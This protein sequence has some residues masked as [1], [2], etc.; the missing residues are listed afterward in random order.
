MKTKHRLEGEI[1][2]IKQCVNKMAGSP[3]F[4]ESSFLPIPTVLAAVSTYWMHPW[5]QMPLLLFSLWGTYVTQLWSQSTASHS[6][7]SEDLLHTWH[8]SRDGQTGNL[9]SPWSQRVDPV[10]TQPRTPVIF[11][12]RE[13]GL[14]LTHSLSALS[15][16]FTGPK[17]FL[18][19]MNSVSDMNPR[20]L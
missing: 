4:R 20:W 9:C 3:S 10:G 1:R 7:A 5:T 19:A 15:Q 18:R 13:A 8:E 2:Y 12:F 17:W 16:K 11:L 6:M 14:R